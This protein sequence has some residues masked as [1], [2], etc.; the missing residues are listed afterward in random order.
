MPGGTPVG[1]GMLEITVAVQ[2]GFAG[3]IVLV[4]VSKGRLIQNNGD[5][6]NDYNVN[7]YNYGTLSLTKGNIVRLVH[8]NGYWT[9][10]FISR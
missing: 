5:I 2:N 1:L 7:G 6:L 9:P 3:R 8:F 10:M 4:G